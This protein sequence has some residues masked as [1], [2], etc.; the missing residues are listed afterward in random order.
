MLNLPELPTSECKVTLKLPEGEVYMTPT[1]KYGFK[2][3]PPKDALEP[4]KAPLSGA[5]SGEGEI[6]GGAGRYN[7]TLTTN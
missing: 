4:F 7:V 5:M 1:I 2:G 3:V 6:S